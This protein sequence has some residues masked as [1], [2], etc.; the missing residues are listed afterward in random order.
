ML[1]ASTGHGASEDPVQ[2]IR[3]AFKRAADL[4]DGAGSVALNFERQARKPAQG[5]VVA[6]LNISNDTQRFD[7]TG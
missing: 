2:N 3:V 1:A 4:D 6:A 7:A 5:I